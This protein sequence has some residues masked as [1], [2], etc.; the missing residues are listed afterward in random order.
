M[1]Q[2][3]FELNLNKIVTLILTYVALSA[4]IQLKCPLNR[5]NSGAHSLSDLDLFLN[6][7]VFKFTNNF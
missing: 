7:V 6:A 1:P 4:V 5:V 3:H 2:C